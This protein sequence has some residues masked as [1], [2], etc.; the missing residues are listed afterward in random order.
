MDA[1]LWGA[2]P[3]RKSG[4][5]GWSQVKCSRQLSPQQCSDDQATRQNIVEIED[6]YGGGR[7]NVETYS[8][9][10][11]WCEG[12]HQ[13]VPIRWVLDSDRQAEAERQAFISTDINHTQMQTRVGM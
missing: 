8:E 2:A 1:E 7:R 13:P 9:I 4:Q 11:V 5:N 12:G 3:E 6:G 10:C